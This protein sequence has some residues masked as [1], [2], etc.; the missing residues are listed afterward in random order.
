MS[1]VCGTLSYVEVSCYISWQCVQA[2]KRVELGLGIEYR[3]SI[4]MELEAGNTTPSVEKTGELRQYH[5]GYSTEL[6]PDGGARYRHI[7]ALPSGRTEMLTT[8]TNTACPV[9]CASF[10]GREFSPWGQCISKRH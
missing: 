2:T 1:S 5:W 8:F 4:Y 7:H 9:R 6:S 3:S 10:Y